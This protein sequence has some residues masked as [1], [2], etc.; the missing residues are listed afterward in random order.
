MKEPSDVGWGE[1]MQQYEAMDK[2]WVEDY[3]NR[4]ISSGVNR[5]RPA[6]MEAVKKPATDRINI[7]ISTADCIM[8]NWQLTDEAHQELKTL[9]QELVD[10]EKLLIT[11][12][13][14]GFV[15]LVYAIIDNFYIKHNDVEKIPEPL[16]ALSIHCNHDLTYLRDYIDKM[17][18]C[19]PE[20]DET[21]LDPWTVKHDCLRN[22]INVLSGGYGFNKHAVNLFLTKP[23][24]IRSSIIMALPA[25]KHFCYQMMMLMS[26]SP[27]IEDVE[28]VPEMLVK[29]VSNQP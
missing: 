17:C 10:E 16:L 6:W 29:A 5:P 11:D 1:L 8:E 28:E 13:T 3:T 4:F 21:D 9:A 12:S 22:L 20:S 24:L 15:K 19:C 25:E 18:H 7:W 14:P 2:L 26:L 23:E 27:N